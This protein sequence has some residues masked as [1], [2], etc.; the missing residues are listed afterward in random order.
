MSVSDP[1]HWNAVYSEKGEAQTSW[2]RPHL[3]ESLRLIDGLHLPLS[4]AL[5]D[6]G[7]GRATL[8]D[9]LLARGF[10]EVSVL[11]LS[12]AALTESRQRL[13]TQASAVQWLV[14]DVTAVELQ[15][16]HYVLWH[17]RA[18]FHFLTAPVAQAAYVAAATRAVRA[19]GYIVIG[20][21][22]EDGPTQC[23]G[24]AVARYDVETLAAMFA[25]AFEKIS[26]SRD[27]HRTPAGN[28]QAFTYV[29]LRRRD[30]GTSA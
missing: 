20:T 6:V 22:A 17:D 28:E 16:A 8:V 5:L 30:D 26:S 15:A 23:S 14:G 9:D 4:S 25:P 2:F 10:G 19:G 11:D 3:D 1:S 7:G 29:V 12:D 13:G 18:V 27:V 21:F 24:L